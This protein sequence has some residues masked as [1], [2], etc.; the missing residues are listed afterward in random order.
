MRAFLI[1]W[2]LVWCN[3]FDPEGSAVLS[4]HL[5]LKRT[6]VHTHSGNAGVAPF[7][8]ARVAPHGTQ[9]EPPMKALSRRRALAWHVDR[10]PNTYKDSMAL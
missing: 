8:V 5:L 3:S 1:L 6:A 4:Y 9:I 2:V 7:R 10:P